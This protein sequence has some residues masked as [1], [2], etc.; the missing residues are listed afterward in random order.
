[1]DLK[2]AY[3]NV[4]IEG[5]LYKLWFEYKL[6]DRLFWWIASFMTGRTSRV[7][8]NGTSS[9]V[10]HLDRGVPQG[11]PLSPMLFLLFITSNQ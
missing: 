2:G 8:V 3:D 6:R 5:L 10:F 7:R 1:M 11:S 4:W 9:E